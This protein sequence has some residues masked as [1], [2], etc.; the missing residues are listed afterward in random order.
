MGNKPMAYKISEP[1][2]KLPGEG[3]RE[4]YSEGTFREDNRA[5]QAGLIVDGGFGDLSSSYKGSTPALVPISPELISAAS[6]IASESESGD[7]GGDVGGDAGGD[8]SESSE[9]VLG[10]MGGNSDST[11]DDMT[12]RRH[13]REKEN[14]KRLAETVSTKNIGGNLAKRDLV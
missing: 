5:M 9:T 1:T 11:V 3:S 4:N 13:E 14:N 2:Y 7:T 12:K 8:T 10:D 6:Q